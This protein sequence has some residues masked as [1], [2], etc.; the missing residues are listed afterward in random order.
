MRVFL[1]IA[2]LFCQATGVAAQITPLFSQK[3]FHELGA[4]ASG[5]FPRRDVEEMVRRFSGFTP[6]KGG[7][8][9][10]AFLA[11]RLTR[12]GF[13]DVVTESFPSDGKTFVGAFLGEPAWDV[14]SATLTMVE[15]G[16]QR[17]ADFGEHRIVLGRFSSSADIV[18]DVI[19]VGDGTAPA[20]Y[21]SKEVRGKVVLVT[22][23]AQAAHR[24]AVWRRGAAGIIWIRPSSIDT[25]DLISNPGLGNRS[26]VRGEAPWRGP[27]GAP[28]G[29]LF[30]VSH[31]LG[32]ELRSL[33]R[34]RQVRVR[35]QIKATTGPGNYHQVEG[36]IR[37]TDPQLKELW[38]K[39]HSNYRNGGGA[40]NLGAVGATIEVGRV[41]SELIRKGILP[42]PKR[43]IRFQYSGDLF[44]V[45][46][47]FVKDPD[48][49]KRPFAFFSVDQIGYH[50]SLV[51]GVLRVYRSPHSRPHYLNDVVEEFTVAVGRANTSSGRGGENGYDPLFAP[52]GSREPFRYVVEDFW[53]PS[54]HEPM[55]E[56]SIGV[57]SVEYGHPTRFGG[58][59]AD[60]VD[61]LDPTQLRRSVQLIAATAYYLANA[62]ADDTPQLVTS[63]LGRAQGRMGRELV[64]ARQLI[65]KSSSTE[66]ATKY[67]EALNIIRQSRLREKAAVESIREI[68]ATAETEREL[69]SAL[70]D[71]DGIATA[72]ETWLRQSANERARVLKSAAPIAAPTPEQQRLDRV[73]PTRTTLIR[74]P[75]NLWRPE[76]GAAWI[77]QQT[78]D[79]NVL[80]Q[81]PLSKQGQY[82]PYEAL[83]FVDGKRSLLEIR[84]AVSAEYGPLIDADLEQYFIWLERL[85]IVSLNRR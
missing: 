70:A 14:E 85:G 55:A 39:A 83:N 19:D 79:S 74:G 23:D 75:L 54:D 28:P 3:L 26:G 62:S 31:R 61:T 25:P 46:Y 84:D 51:G 43:T 35:V 4:E 24:E 52:T 10:A 30:G 67:R 80:A 81:V 40:H 27:N 33:L 13:D 78:G 22:G 72:N 48:K 77:A 36:I 47:Q 18:A 66:L 6:S 29:F 8:D 63:V 60:T 53:G 34:S 5:E 59:Q 15:P 11:Q 42:R 65:D 73:V 21:E 37:G 58:T 16:V 56:G 17:L 76:Y 50:Q 82:V 57:P 71:V 7:D 44:P 1:A 64:R 38:I 32:D 49:L 41:L 69:T 45:V 9:M 20:H 2:I 12:A 68:S